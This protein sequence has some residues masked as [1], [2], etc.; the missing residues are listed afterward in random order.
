M[1]FCRVLSLRLWVVLAL[2]GCRGLTGSACEE[3]SCLKAHDLMSMIDMQDI[4][5][6]RMHKLMH[7]LNHYAHIMPASGRHIIVS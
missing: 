1:I 2:H 6:P 5:E 3:P 7:G 4:H